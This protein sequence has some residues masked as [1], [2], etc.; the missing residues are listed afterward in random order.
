M[1]QLSH[2]LFA[3]VDAAAPAIKELSARTDRHPNFAVQSFAK[4]KLDGDD[5]PESGTEVGRNTAMAVGI[6]GGAG[7]LLGLGAGMS[8]AIIGLNAGMGAAVGGLFGSVVG[9]LSGMMAGTRVPKARLRELAESQGPDELLVTVETDDPAHAEL[10]REILE[11][12]GG[13]QVG[14]C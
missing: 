13:R 6:G 8:E 3:D 4:G 7:V 14:D 2:A 9:V 10:V 1:P 12:A 11:S 5:L